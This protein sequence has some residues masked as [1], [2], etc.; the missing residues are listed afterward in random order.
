MPA[1]SCP[2][3]AYPCHT[4]RVFSRISAAT[5]QG[6]ADAA[7]AHHE[8][9]ISSRPCNVGLACKRK[10]TDTAFVLLMRAQPVVASCVFSR[11]GA[12]QAEVDTCHAGSAT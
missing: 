3:F 2:G 12:Y 6:C 11:S 9:D 10:N 8:I 4:K 1:A 7:V 5:E